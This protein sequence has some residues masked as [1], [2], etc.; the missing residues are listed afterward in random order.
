MGVSSNVTISERFLPPAV[1]GRGG[2]MSKL[3]Y[4]DSFRITPSGRLYMKLHG[5]ER[6][7]EVHYPYDGEVEIYGYTR[8]ESFTDHT[9]SRFLAKFVCGRLVSLEKVYEGDV[10]T[11]WMHLYH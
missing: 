8:Y 5:L 2:Y 10:Q 1:K 6:D 7:V 9:F 11:A 4:G 3:G